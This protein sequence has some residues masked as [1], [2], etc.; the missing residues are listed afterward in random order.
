MRFT[1]HYSGGNATRMGVFSLFYSIPGTYWHRVLAERQ[2]P[3][4][5]D[6]VLR[7]GYD[8]RVFRSAPLYSPEFDRT[9]FAHVPAP[10][11]RSDGDTPAQRDRDL[12]LDFATFLESRADSSP[13]FAVLFYDSPHSF[14]VPPLYP[15]PFQPSA[16]Q[17]N[18]LSLRSSTDPRPLLNRYRNSIH[19]ID[20]LIGTVFDSL[21]R[22]EAL[23]DAVI[24]VTGDHGQ[25]FND[26]RLN[27]WGHSSN[28]SRHQTGVPLLLFDAKRAAAVMHHRTTHYDVMPTLMRE[29]LGCD[30][31][32]E[33]HSVGRP[34]FEPGGRDPMIL[35]AYDEFAI[36]QTD[37]VAVI[38]KFGLQMRG[39]DYSRHEGALDAR[40]VAAALE[41]NSRFH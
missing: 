13:F 28:Y 1:N 30:E 40:A 23:E 25:E 9:V 38:D 14:D 37:R 27:Y 34:L 24:I 41:Q 3:V 20:S 12:T 4:V 2:G 22:H 8:V 5:I 35:S 21:R 33:T 7:Q 29:Y 17:V 18:Y 15:L 11:M 39:T 36:M 19:Y 32:Y 16:A 26:N 10:R 6:E 31:P